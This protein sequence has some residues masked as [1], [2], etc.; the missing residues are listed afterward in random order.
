LS[1]RSCNKFQTAS[2]IWLTRSEQTHWIF[3]LVA[4]GP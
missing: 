4:N 3:Y 1:Q 2:A